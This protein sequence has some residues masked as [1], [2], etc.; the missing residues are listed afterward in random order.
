MSTRTVSGLRASLRDIFPAALVFTSALAACVFLFNSAPPLARAQQI[1]QP[2]PA[3]SQETFAAPEDAVHALAA[4]VE[5]ND[6]SA[7]GGIFGSEYSQ[8]LSGD[9]VQD[10][11]NLTKFAEALQQASDLQKD[12]D[13]KYTLL[14]GADKWPMPIPI[15]SRDRRWLFDTQA[16]LEE[17]LDRRIGEDELA[18]MT[19]CRAYVL[20]QWEY[21][22]SG[23]HDNDGVAEYARKFMSSPGQHD[24]LYWETSEGEPSSPLG[25]LVAEARA[26]GY[27]PRQRARRD[28][29]GSRRGNPENSAG[30]R[31]AFHGYFFKILTAQGPHAPGGKYN[32]IINGNMIGGFALLAYP[33]K[34]GNSGVMSFIV[35]QQGRVYQKNLGRDTVKL[36]GSITIYDPD[37]SWGIVDTI[38]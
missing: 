20:A 27:G 6:Q 36:A 38:E 11:A 24:G 33:E 1:A 30:P 5:A 8:L 10:R 26:E 4:A 21:F 18:A 15:V 28:S 22:T 32:Y 9:R 17:I 37:A 14:V 35:N 29:S 3:A 23:D 2:Q 25:S 31:H 13:G 16:G 7:L 34:W 12:S 19:T